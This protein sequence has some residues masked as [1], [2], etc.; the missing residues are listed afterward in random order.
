MKKRIIFATVLSCVLASIVFAQSS[1]AT[2][3]EI[4]D[5]DSR[6]AKM[7]PVPRQIDVSVDVVGLEIGENST[8]E[9]QLSRTASAGTGTYYPVADA[10]DLSKVFSKVTTGAGMG[11]GGG[12]LYRQASPVNWPLLIGVFFLVGSGILL[13]GLLIVRARRSLPRMVPGTHIAATLDI[14]YGDG[15]TKSVPILHSQSFIGRGEGNDVVIPDPDVSGTHAELSVTRDGF[16]LRD[17]GSTN[18]TFVNGTRI[19]EQF[20]YLNDEIQMGSTRLV[21][22]E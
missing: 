15:G 22:R 17:A 18:G 4:E 1:Q 8:A 5:F 6:V 11:G 16:F 19:S 3:P 10:A 13:V 21:F 12:V 7:K 2:D 9:Q 14:F 20:L